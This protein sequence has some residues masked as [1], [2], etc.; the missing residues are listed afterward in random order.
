MTSNREARCTGHCCKN[1]ALE[2]SYA[3][4]QEDY[5]NWLRD[6]K[7][8]KIPQIEIIAPMLKPLRS[9]PKH[10]EYV[11]TCKNLTSTGDCGIYQVRPQMCRDFPETDG[12]HFWKCTSDQSCYFG[13]SFF[14]KLRVRYRWLKGFGRPL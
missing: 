14:K 12:C 3:E 6:P 8:S 1:F 13:L 4:I 10:S 5:E 11:Y 7:S 2:Y 9:D